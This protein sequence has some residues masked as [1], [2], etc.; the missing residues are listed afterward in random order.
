MM[1]RC[2]SSSRTAGPARSSSRLKIIDPLANPTAQGASASDAFHLVIPSLPG[3]GFSAK[4]AA[5]GWDPARIARAWVVLMKR[6]GYP[7][8][9]SQGGDWGGAVTNVM[10]QQAPP[11]I[12]GIHVNFPGTVPPTSPRR[13]SAATRRR[14][15]SPPTKHAYEQLTTLYTRRRAY[16]AMMGTRPQTLYG[17]T[18]S[19]PAGWTEQAYHNLIYYNKVGKGG[20]FAAWE[21]P[22]LF[23][24]E[25]RAGFRPLRNRAR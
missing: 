21:Q 3:Y 22:Q 25:V 14:P 20:H 12:L 9:V 17:L 15:A 6:L 1:M 16:A 18:D 11:E 2:R 7:Q 4:P 5:T 10:A 8:F 19:G 13:S 24:A 23:S